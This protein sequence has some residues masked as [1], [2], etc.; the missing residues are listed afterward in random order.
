MRG[1]NEVEDDERR[2]DE[3]Q[4]RRERVARTQLESQILP[5]ER[6]NVCEVTDHARLSRAVVWG[7]RRSGS[8]VATRKAASMRR[9][10]SSRSSKL[11]PASSNPSYGSSRTIRAG[12]CRDVRQSAIRCNRL[13][14]YVPTPPCGP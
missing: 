10:A 12:S 6:P 8:C 11:A 9:S 2:E 7:S 4:H 5:R 1:K 13:R 14:E 3:Q